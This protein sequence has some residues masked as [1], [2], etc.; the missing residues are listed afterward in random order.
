[1]NMITNLIAS[2]TNDRITSRSRMAHTVVAVSINK[3]YRN[4]KIVIVLSSM[5]LMPF[6]AVRVMVLCIL[7]CLDHQR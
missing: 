5:A 3:A 4:S 6:P 7:E 1:M 2:H